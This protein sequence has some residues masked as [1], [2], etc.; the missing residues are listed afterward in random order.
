[1]SNCIFYYGGGSFYEQLAQ[2]VQ[3]FVNSPTQI[4]KFLVLGEPYGH[5]VPATD[6]IGT[7]G[8]G[9]IQEDVKLHILTQC[10]PEMNVHLNLLCGG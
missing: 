9:H 6:Q 5:T 7:W 3:V 2:L 8:L 10:R 1:M 4:S